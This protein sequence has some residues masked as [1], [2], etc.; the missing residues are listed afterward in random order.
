[1]TR[2]LSN[3]L[4]ERV[5]A[6]IEAGESCRSV[7]ARFGIAVSS[8][9]KW[10]QRYRSSGSV[11]PGKMG[12]HR[13]RVLEPHRTFIVERINQTPHVSLHRL[14]EELAARGVKVS[15][16]TVWQ[17]LRREGLRFKKTLFALEQARA[18]VA[19]RR[20]RWRSWQAGL[21]PRRLVFIDKT[22]IKT[23]MAPLRGWGPKGKRL[24]SFAPHGHWRTL[25][26]LGALRC[27]RLTAP[28]V[29]D[30]PINGECFRAYVEQQLV[31]VLK[32]GDIVVMDNLGSHKS[33]AIRQMIRNAGARLWYLPPYSP[34]LNPIERAF[35][36][37]KHWMRLAQKRTIDD[38]WRHI[39][40]PVKTIEPS[41]CSNYFANAGYASVKT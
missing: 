8:A 17:F 5:V 37:I 38:T 7:A 30:G 29:F 16:G 22:W 20:Q 13:K 35:A 15:H 10:S 4:R 24:R 26:F 18:D 1:M 33:V 28:C 6:A 41:E 19:R 40:H 36:K 23:N 3:D 34:D 27:D 9:V 11:A 31:L 39:G 12:G 32:P 2:P 14:K 21:D 25:T